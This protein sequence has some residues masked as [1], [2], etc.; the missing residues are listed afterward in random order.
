MGHL[1]LSLQ[2]KQQTMHV[3]MADPPQSGALPPAAPVSGPSPHPTLAP[4]PCQ[5][6]GLEFFPLLDPDLVL[7]NQS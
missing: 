6:P 4:D 1:R 5:R 2:R 7:Q 3:R